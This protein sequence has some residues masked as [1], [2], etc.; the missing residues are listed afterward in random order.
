MG[1]RFGQVAEA[2][3]EDEGQHDIVEGGVVGG[4]M[5]GA[6]A[7]GVFAE[8]GIAAV[9]V[10]V[11]NLPVVAV[12]LEQSFGAG[13]LGRHGG[14][15]VGGL[16]AGLA[17]FQAGAGTGDTAPLAGGVKDEQAG[18]QGLHVDAPG[19]NTPVPLLGRAGMMTHARTPSSRARSALRGSPD[20][21]L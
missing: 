4:G 2:L 7:A 5:P 9:V 17:G 15:A 12:P 10:A 19:L 21:C 11:L 20:S 13:L 16:L 18:W 3:V 8:G 1:I 6:V 14:D